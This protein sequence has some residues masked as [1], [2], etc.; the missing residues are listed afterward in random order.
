[1]REI[2][3]SYSFDFLKVQGYWLVKN[4]IY[5]S[6][7]PNKFVIYILLMKEIFD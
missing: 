6:G 2:F 5:I 4:F 7:K 3:P 1:M